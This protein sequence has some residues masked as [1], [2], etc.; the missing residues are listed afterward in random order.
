MSAGTAELV[1]AD[2]SKIEQ[3]ESRSPECLF[4]VL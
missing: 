3:D 1:S 2:I 4:T